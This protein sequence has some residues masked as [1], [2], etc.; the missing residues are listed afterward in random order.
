MQQIWE[1][2]ATADFN[3]SGYNR[4]KNFRAL[5]AQLS[6]SPPTLK[7]VSTPLQFIMTLCIHVKSGKKRG[8]AGDEATRSRGLC[9]HTQIQ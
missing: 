6:Q 9:V 1:I 4:I 2:I 8:R 7:I 3:G 5:C